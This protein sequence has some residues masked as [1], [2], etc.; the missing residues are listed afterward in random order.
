MRKLFSDCYKKLDF[1]KVWKGTR[2]C[3][4][5]Q[6]S[7]GVL[8]LCIRVRPATTGTFSKILKNILQVTRPNAHRENKW[9]LNTSP[10][11][12]MWGSPELEEYHGLTTGYVNWWALNHG[13]GFSRGRLIREDSTR[14]KYLKQQCERKQSSGNIYTRLDEPLIF[15]PSLK[16]YPR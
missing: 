14:G 10:F 3:P 5:R 6:V 7:T 4:W 15:L 8:V 1:K 2:K 16:C 13:S 11:T 9:A 12:D